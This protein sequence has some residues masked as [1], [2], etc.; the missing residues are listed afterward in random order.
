MAKLLLRL[1]FL[2]VI[3]SF[4]AVSMAQKKLKTIIID[5]GH[6]Y[7]GPNK[8]SPDGAPGR[9]C[10][11]DDVALAVSLKLEALILKKFPELS[12]VQ[13]RPDDDFITLGTRSKI[14]NENKG[15]LFI[16]I[17]VNDADTHREKVLDSFKLV[18]KYRNEKDSSGKTI[19]VPYE[20]QV[21]VYKWQRVGCSAF[22]AQSYVWIARNNFAKINAEKDGLNDEGDTSLQKVSKIQAAL[23][24]KKY[25][26]KSVMMSQFVQDEFKAIGRKFGSGDA[27]YQRPKG[28]HVLEATSMPSLLIET[29]FICNNKD[30]KY[31]CSNEGQQELAECILRAFIKYKSKVETPNTSSSTAKK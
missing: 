8:T 4:G 20:D 15:D 17:H 21:A 25:F 28:I 2:A 26:K 6:G 29:G 13:T 5:A 12:I 30:E 16:C 27:I 3:L 9:L 24:V 22:G 11:E 10:N 18:T 23:N 19:K 14:A 31:L 1:S 7:K